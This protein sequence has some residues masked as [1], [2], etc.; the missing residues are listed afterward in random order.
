MKNQAPVSDART[1]LF[2][3]PTCPNCK[4]AVPML[5]K[6]GL[7]FEKIYA[8]DQPNLAKSFGVMQAPTLVVSDGKE[9]KK[10]TGVSEIKNYVNSIK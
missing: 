2:A 10:Y 6:A 5:E 7:P 1:I 9:Y 3:T 4:I 8:N